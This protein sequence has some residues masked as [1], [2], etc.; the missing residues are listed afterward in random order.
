MLYTHT[1]Q[2]FNIKN[3]DVES[4]QIVREL[5]RNMPYPFSE[6]KMRQNN[7]IFFKEMDKEKILGTINLINETI[8]DIK[9]LIQTNNLIYEQINLVRAITML[10]E[11][12]E[13]LV[14]NVEYAEELYSWKGDYIKEITYVLNSIPKAKTTEEKIELDKKLTEIF[15]KVLRS[16]RFEYN[17]SDIINE[18]QTARMNDLHESMK[19]GFFFHFTVDEHLR[20]LDFLIIKQRIPA[21]EL[22][23]VEKI[24]KNISEIKQ[25]V[26]LV[27]NF[28]INMMQLAVYLYSY[29][30][31][32]NSG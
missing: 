16:N 7:E 29:V 23:P 8:E 31:W 28:N 4:V 6:D 32:V 11:I 15:Q 25:N 24:M 19:S 30:K 14:K 17:F 20:K 10:Q 5:K 22:D 9:A 2:D 1:L 12:P 21:K 13:R 27:Y 3:V 26:D 18:A